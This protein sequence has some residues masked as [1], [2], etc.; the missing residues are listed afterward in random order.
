MLGIAKRLRG[1]IYSK[2]WLLDRT[3]P[4][5]SSGRHLLWIDAA[6]E[7]WA[8]VVKRTRAGEIYLLSY[9]RARRG[10]PESSRKG[11]RTREDGIW[12]G[13]Q[14]PSSAR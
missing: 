11:A 7:P 8:A 4:P 13:P 6:G 10:E 5:S 9:R 3:S 14:S 1:W 2:R 12:G